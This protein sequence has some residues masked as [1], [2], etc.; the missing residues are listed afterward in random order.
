MTIMIIAKGIAPEVHK[1]V[2]SKRVSTDRAEW[3]GLLLRANRVPGHLIK[4]YIIALDGLS[5]TWASQ[6]VRMEGPVSEYNKSLSTKWFLAAIALET[7]RMPSNT[8]CL[9]ALAP[10]WF[11]TALAI[12]HDLP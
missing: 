10:E 1:V 6:A 5:A 8:H 3:G 4:F 9:N 7:T 2:L 12:V 11:F